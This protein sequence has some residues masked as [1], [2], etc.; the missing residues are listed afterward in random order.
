MFLL[1]FWK[2]W[3]DSDVM[4]ASTLRGYIICENFFEQ[5]EH[6]MGTHRKWV[7]LQFITNTRDSRP[8]GI[9]LLILFGILDQGH[10]HIVMKTKDSTLPSY[11]VWWRVESWNT[12][13]LFVDCRKFKTKLQQP[14]AVSHLLT[15]KSMWTEKAWNWNGSWFMVNVTFSH[16][17]Q[18]DRFL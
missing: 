7:L 1:P 17:T 10:S 14:L 16:S 6:R 3:E 13:V 11:F 5:W 8:N 4:L 18:Q 2:Q 9:R 15:R 12:T